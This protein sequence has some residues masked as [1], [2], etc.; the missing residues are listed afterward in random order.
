MKRLIPLILSILVVTS[1]SAQ[2]DAFRKMRLGFEELV[3]DN[4]STALT[5]FNQ[6][7]D[8]AITN[9]D[10]EARAT[11]LFYMGIASYGSS[12]QNGLD[13]ANRSL[14]IYKSIEEKKPNVARLGKARVLQ[15]LATIHAREGNLNASI[16]KSHEALILL[17]DIQ[18]TN[19]TLGIIYQS[20][21]QIYAQLQKTDSSDLYIKK[22]L[23]IRIQNKDSVY[24]P[25]S[26][27]R[28][29]DILLRRKEYT[30]SKELYNTALDIAFIKENRQA[31]V[32]ALLGVS[33][34]YDS[35]P[36]S[37][38]KVD[39]TIGLAHSIANSLS[40]K[41]FLLSVMNAYASISE[42]N[43]ELQSALYWRSRIQGLKDTL[44]NLEKDRVLKSMEIQFDVEEKE[45][46]I[47]LKEKEIKSAKK[48]NLMLGIGLA[49]VIV[50]AIMFILFLKRLHN[51]K[52]ELSS[53]QNQLDLLT[54]DS[55]RKSE[56]MIR[57]ELEY[58][59]SQLT[60]IT[61]QMIQKSEL[62]NEIKE[63]L[64]SSSSGMDQSM[65]KLLHK[66]MLQEQD[67]MAFEK[68]FEAINKNF[69]QKLNDRFP[70]M[71]P[72][73]MKICALIKM[74]LS[75][76][77]MAGILN[78]SAESVKTARYRLRKKLELNTEDNLT[79][80]IVSL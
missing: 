71:S 58:K 28:N 32:A 4:D 72:N 24:L 29:A 12:L 11:S 73:D 30:R 74:N 31:Q 50:G 35:Q 3:K 75:I 21:G 59:E 70:G 54:L 15:L 19:G 67:W 53:K 39:S 23:D 42:K 27:V 57:N 49:V 55:V 44:Y 66:G 79:E 62:I 5:L 13:F 26:Y 48:I 1:I 40:D 60:A 43:Q 20:L 14:R 6:A 68:S 78:I 80:F 65:Q 77:E 17:T 8:L 18:D 45:H 2:E 38:S 46:R 34:W 7:H 63:K 64:E 25:T 16:S 47:E 22:A 10:D 37:R 61:L 36:D 56:L 41:H 51:F 33:R 9:S 52:Q 76:K 69:Y